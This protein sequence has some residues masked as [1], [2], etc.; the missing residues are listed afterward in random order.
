MRHPFVRSAALVGGALLAA[1]CAS[2]GSS[3][4]TT[5]S[6][7]T[8]APSTSAS[9]ASAPAPRRS[10]RT[11]LMPDEIATTRESNMYDVV[12]KLRP[13]WLQT[14]GV[15]SRD[16]EA[17]QIQVYLDGVKQDGG[18]QSLR[19]IEPAR[20]TAAQRIDGADATTRFGMGNS[21]GAILIST[22]PL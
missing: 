8:P 12:S 22:R 4:G 18:V 1:A 3:A 6:S 5:V 20:V 19:Q 14:R 7:P 13:Q 15:A 11:R 21:G 9:V 10:D 2:S 17:T 16:A